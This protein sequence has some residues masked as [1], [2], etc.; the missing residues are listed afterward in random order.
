MK[1]TMLGIGC[2]LLMLLSW[3]VGAYDEDD[4]KKLLETKECQK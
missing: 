4:L 3:Q 1:R 2:L